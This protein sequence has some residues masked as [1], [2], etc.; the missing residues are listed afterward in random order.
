MAFVQRFTIQRLTPSYRTEWYMNA[1]QWSTDEDDAEEFRTFGI[2]PR[3]RISKV[4]AR[5][6]LSLAPYKKENEMTKHVE[7]LEQANVRIE[8]LIWVPGAVAAMS[9][10]EDLQELLGSELYNNKAKDQIL[11][12]LPKLAPL[13][14]S[15]EEPDEDLISDA[16]YRVSGY[17]AQMARPIPTDFLS[18]H[19]HAFS[20]GYYQ[21]KW[22]YVDDMDELVTLA[23]AFS[24]E[25]VQR[26]WKKHQAS[27]A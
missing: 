3:R 16:L 21:T 19:S 17:F 22:V 15:E 13:L 23:E 8:K 26:A 11:G 7:R 18:E 6:I 27:A 12:K 4:T 1:D 20:W 2:R 14:E 24:E 9:V 25:V 5:E 10:P